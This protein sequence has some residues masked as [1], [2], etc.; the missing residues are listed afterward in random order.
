MTK[1]LENFVVK[2]AYYNKLDATTA[3]RNVFF[4]IERECMK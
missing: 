2:N 3:T 4:A 1:L